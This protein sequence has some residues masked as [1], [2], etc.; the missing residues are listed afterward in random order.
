MHNLSLPLLKEAVLALLPL[1]H[2]SSDWL[3]LA[4]R[5]IPE[6]V[7]GASVRSLYQHHAELKIEKHLMETL[8]LKGLEA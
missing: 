1:S 3:S 5:S 2:V 7:G 6:Q 8:C 4:N